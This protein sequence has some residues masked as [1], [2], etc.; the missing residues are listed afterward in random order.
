MNTNSFENKPTVQFLGHN[1]T[2]RDLIFIPSADVIVSCSNDKSIRMWSLT[3]GTCLKTINIHSDAVNTICLMSNGKTLLSGSSDFV[4][5]IFT[6]EN[7]V[8]GVDLKL[9]SKCND[10]SAI[11]LITSFYNNSEYAMAVNTEGKFR[12]W[13][14]KQRVCLH[15]IAGH[16]MSSVVYGVLIIT[17]FKEQDIFVMSFAKNERNPR[18]CNIDANESEE[19]F[20][21]N[22]Y[23]IDLPINKSGN[24]IMQIIDGQSD[25][26]FNFC[27]VCDEGLTA[28]GSKISFFI[29]K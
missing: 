24:P 25:K 9:E 21:A 7:S 26:G 5:G 19:L 2:V 15:T 11:T 4:L 1:D 8:K 3:E 13:N 14:V 10:S 17:C 29:F 27:I 12:I 20:V 23:K 28:P 16:L 22:D 6:F 18:I